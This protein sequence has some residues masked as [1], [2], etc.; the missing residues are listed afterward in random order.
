MTYADILSPVALDSQ[1]NAEY[2][3]EAAPWPRASL[4]GLA[5]RHP[6]RPTPRRRAR[7]ESLRTEHRLASE[8]RSP[9]PVGDVCG[10]QPIQFAAG[11]SRQ[12]FL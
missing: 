12:I 7:P 5:R 6:H 3:L 1:Q 2:E 9:D 10:C 4:E 11:S 8:R